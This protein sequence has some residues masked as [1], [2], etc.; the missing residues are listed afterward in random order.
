[1][2]IEITIMFN[3]GLLFDWVQSD[4][5]KK[6]LQALW[7][8][9]V[10]EENQNILQKEN[11]KKK[12]NAFKKAYQKLREQQ[13]FARKNAFENQHKKLINDLSSFGNLINLD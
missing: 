10:E 2:L 3:N 6:R 1:M 13:I 9:A 11:N 7:D 8:E 5:D 12:L 4:D